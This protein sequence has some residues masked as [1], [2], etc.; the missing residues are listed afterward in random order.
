MCRAGA[1]NRPVDLSGLSLQMSMGVVSRIVG[2]TN[3]SIPRMSARLDAF[4]IGQTGD[5]RAS[6]RSVLQAVRTHSALLRFSYLDVK[7]AIAR[8]RKRRRDDVI[9]QLL[10]QGFSELEIL[11]ECITYAAAGMATTRQFLV[12]AAWHLLD[13]PHLLSRYRAARPTNDSR[14]STR[15]FGSNRWLAGSTAE[16]PLR[17]P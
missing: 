16:P 7:P 3:S 6:P 9:S 1:P 15:F 5:V 13:D 2:L 14:S 10:D 4:F 17:L 8:R 11:T 12:V